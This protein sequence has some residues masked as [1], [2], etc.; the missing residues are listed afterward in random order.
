MTDENQ[1]EQD[2]EDQGQ[3]N[4]GAEWSVHAH[5]QYIK[6][7]SFENPNA[8]ESLSEE[9]GPD[10]PAVN[11]NYE[12]TINKLSD[13]TFEVV[14][15][16]QGAAKRGPKTLFLV[17]LDYAGLFTLSGIPADRI[18]AILHVH[19]PT[20]LFPFARSIIADVTRE[21]GYPAL[22]I[23]TLDFAQVFERFKASKQNGAD[24]GED[25]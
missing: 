14:I 11:V 17:T 12:L 4:E 24:T 13:A 23:N 10:G 15:H 20:L 2:P 16:I 18:D 22:L 19:C 1:A 6:D 21:G 9:E 5:T 3:E 25:G 8:L 7:L